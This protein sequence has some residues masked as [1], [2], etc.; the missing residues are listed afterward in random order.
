LIDR[1]QQRAK[2]CRKLKG[3]VWDTWPGKHAS[4]LAMRV[5]LDVVLEWT[6]NA[7]PGTSAASHRA[8]PLKG[9][10]ILAFLRALVGAFKTFVPR[11]LV[12]AEVYRM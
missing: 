10:S 11:T 5:R 4:S 7:A 1:N 3:H 8:L 12:S 6:L 9:R 2:S